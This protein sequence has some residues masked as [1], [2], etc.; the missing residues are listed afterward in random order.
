V[1][2]ALRI[3]IRMR[4]TFTFSELRSSRCHRCGALRVCCTENRQCDRPALRAAPR[5]CCCV[6][7]VSQSDL[8]QC[9]ARSTCRFRTL[10]Q[11]RSRSIFTAVKNLP[12][13][14]ARV[15]VRLLCERDSPSFFTTTL[16]RIPDDD[17]VFLPSVVG[18]QMCAL[19]QV[20]AAG[21]CGGFDPVDGPV[22][23]T[24]SAERATDFDLLMWIERC[25]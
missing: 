11:P 1:Q 22:E 14:W 24:L 19:R 21:A 15:T 20:S 13:G 10:A 3:E 8:S 4:G 16:R 5:V 18:A 2:C 17:A 6:G 12:A 25:G 7:H 23:F 9:A